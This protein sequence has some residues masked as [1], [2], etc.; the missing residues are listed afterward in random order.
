MVLIVL[1]DRNYKKYAIKKPKTISQ[2]NE[3]GRM[4]E[5]YFI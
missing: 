3:I 2:I 1:R 5:R 4:G